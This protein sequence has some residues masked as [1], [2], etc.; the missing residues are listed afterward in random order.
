M[1]FLALLLRRNPKA[2]RIPSLHPDRGPRVSTRSLHISQDPK[3]TLTIYNY[4]PIHP[5]KASL[6][7]ATEAA[8]RAFFSSPQFAVVGACSDPNKFGHKS[9]SS[10]SSPPSPPSPTLR[11]QFERAESP[12]GGARSQTPQQT[13]S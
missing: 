13:Q 12:T 7:M 9:T 5:M 8:A 10:Q 1:I 4:N 2:A 3:R 6:R 11:P